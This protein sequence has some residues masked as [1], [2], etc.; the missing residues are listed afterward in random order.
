MNPPSPKP[1]PAPGKSLAQLLA[2]G[3]LDAG[4]QKTA[5]QKDGAYSLQ[6]PRVCEVCVCVCGGARQ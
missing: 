1:P 5:Q 3:A 6:S 4:L 2:K